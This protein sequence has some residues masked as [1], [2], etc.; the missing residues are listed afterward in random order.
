MQRHQQKERTG[1]R[2]FIIIPLLMNGRSSEAK[3]KA[4]VHSLKWEL[5]ELCYKERRRGGLAAPSLMKH[6]VMAAGDLFFFSQLGRRGHYFD[7]RGLK[8]C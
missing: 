3:R 8:S 1:S 7:P 4:A 5:F 6:C 2:I